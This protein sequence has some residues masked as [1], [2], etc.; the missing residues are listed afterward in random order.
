MTIEEAINWIRFDIEMARF[1]PLTGYESYLNEDAKKVIEAQ[2]MAIKI[3]RGVINDNKE[4][5]I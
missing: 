1:D 2:E 3:L 4:S 5:G